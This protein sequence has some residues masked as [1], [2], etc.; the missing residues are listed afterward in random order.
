MPRATSVGSY[1]MYISSVLVIMMPS[2]E[3]VSNNDSV[4]ENSNH[5]FIMTFLRFSSRIKAS[6]VYY[7]HLSHVPW[8][9]HSNEESNKVPRLWGNGLL[10]N[11]H[12]EGY[13]RFLSITSV[14]YRPGRRSP[15]NQEQDGKIFTT[16]KQTN[17]QTNKTKF[18][19][20]V[21][22]RNEKKNNVAEKK[23]E[24]SPYPSDS[25]CSSYVAALKTILS[26]ERGV[27]KWY[28]FI[29]SSTWS[30]NAE[31]RFAETK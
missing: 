20:R 8:R 7:L 6:I 16:T 11:L 30:D 18:K 22:A 21:N 12:S 17:K 28:F 31:T 13:T 29:H 23:Y 1:L 15:P 24:S 3:T 27:G 25:N 10:G 2:A 4:R 14:L 5:K 9:L 26:E 19:D